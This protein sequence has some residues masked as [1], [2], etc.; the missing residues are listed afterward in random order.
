M[1]ENLLL[2]LSQHH[3]AIYWF[4]FAWFALLG[5]GA[6]IS[7]WYVLFKLEAPMK[8]VR[9]L[10]TLQLHEPEIIV[11]EPDQYDSSEDENGSPPSYTPETREDQQQGASTLLKPI[12][13]PTFLIFAAIIIVSIVLRRVRQG[14]S[15]CPVFHD[16]DS[17]KISPISSLDM[18]DTY[19]PKNT[20]R[21]ELP[22]QIPKVMR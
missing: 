15:L 4:Q 20:L 12:V 11:I 2:T 10:K 3:T 17:E 8:V 9:R 6:T 5:V 22:I 18:C 7:T 1:R 19:K 21:I 14:H 13:I 16:T